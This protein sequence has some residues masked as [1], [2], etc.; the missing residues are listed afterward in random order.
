MSIVLPQGVDTRVGRWLG[1][2]NRHVCH[3]IPGLS[4]QGI[5]ILENVVIS[6]LR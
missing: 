1:L 5:V 3:E 2:K 4:G 6:R